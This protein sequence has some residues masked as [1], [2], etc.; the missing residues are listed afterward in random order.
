MA[1]LAWANIVADMIYTYS[2]WNLGVLGMA[3]ELG[4]SANSVYGE[5]ADIMLAGDE[6]KGDSRAIVDDGSVD[7]SRNSPWGEES[8]IDI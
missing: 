1:L 5:K 6:I 8:L 2:D 3:G 7:C 4:D